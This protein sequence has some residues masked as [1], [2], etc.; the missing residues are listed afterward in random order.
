MTSKASPSTIAL[1]PDASIISYT[2]PSLANPTQPH[3]TPIAHF[4]SSPNS[5][6]TG[7][8]IAISSFYIVYVV[9]NGL[10]RVID[11]QKALRTL[12]RGHTKRVT[13]LAFFSNV[14]DSSSKSDVLGTVGGEGDLACVFIWR[15]FEDS[16]QQEEI[17]S[18]KLL[19]VR[20][21][22]AVRL[23]WHPLNPNQ[24]FLL[25][26]PNTNQGVE[27]RGG[28]GVIV[29]TTKL[30]TMNHPMEGH[31]V[32]DCGVSGT[33][34]GQAGVFLWSDKFRD[35][36]C[37]D[38][39]WSEWNTDYTILCGGGGNVILWDWKSSGKIVSV[40]PVGEAESEIVDSVMF[41]YRIEG[42]ANNF[43]QND[44]KK[45]LTEPF[46]TGIKGNSQ[47]DLWSNFQT[48]SDGI[49][50][51]ATKMRTFKMTNFPISF[52]LSMCSG[53]QS[54]YDNLKAYIVLSDRNSLNLYAIHV[55][56]E[57]SAPYKIATGFDSITQFQVMHPILS[58]SVMGEMVVDDQEAEDDDDEEGGEKFEI[59][60]FCVQSTAVQMLKLKP[61]MLQRPKTDDGKVNLPSNVKVEY[62]KT[63]EKHEGSK[64]SGAEELDADQYEYED[65]DE[66]T[67][68]LKYETNESEDEVNV[69]PPLAASLPPPGLTSNF[70]ANDSNSFSNW[71]G[72]IASGTTPN[73]ASVLSNTQGQEDKK[74]SIE[75]QSS[76]KEK[77]PTTLKIDSDQQHIQSQPKMFLSPVE[78]ISSSGGEQ[79]KTVPVTR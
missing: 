63:L 58:W 46:V 30:D 42:V 6:P 72:A 14:S 36:G 20:Y 3:T 33:D 69:S 24:F 65:Y 32:C 67:L 71:L 12:L 56:T 73:V 37:I 66:S 44:M 26:R 17:G 62:S 55:G 11:R 8:L 41:V 64:E 1:P 79:N 5:H 48:M 25:N 23:I 50:I 53:A 75:D 4:A 61:K 9:K 47:I 38:F 40:L 57:Q 7:S 51:G 15:I 18:E 60:L 39:S 78:L 45:Y 31:A 34:L 68:E 22:P 35:V 2:T 74:E 13:D 59:S 10:V 29:E 43:D 27:Q 19:E 16:T 49:T 21:K 28:G 70:N 77:T 52:H 54:F 76:S